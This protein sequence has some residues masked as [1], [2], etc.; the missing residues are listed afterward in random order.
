MR[1]DKP[2]TSIVPVPEYASPLDDKQVPEYKYFYQADDNAQ[3]PKHDTRGNPGL[4]T[5]HTE[6]VRCWK[7]GKGRANE[8]DKVARISPRDDAPILASAHPRAVSPFLARADTVGAH[9]Q[10]SHHSGEELP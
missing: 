7:S 10:T 6:G 4:Q 1:T 8:G 9:A 2:D 3:V 5:H